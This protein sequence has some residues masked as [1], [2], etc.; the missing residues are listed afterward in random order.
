MDISGIFILLDATKTLSSFFEDEQLK[1]FNLK[2]SLNPKDKKCINS[3]ASKDVCEQFSKVIAPKRRGRPPK[4]TE[5]IVQNEVPRKNEKN[6]TI[7]KKE[8]SKQNP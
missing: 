6:R 5:N 4:C 1:N 8:S 2:G 3:N 7:K